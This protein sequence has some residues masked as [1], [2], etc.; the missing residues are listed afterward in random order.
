M[1][2][3]TVGVQ[4]VEIDGPSPEEAVEETTVRTQ[5]LRMHCPGQR[6]KVRER[7]VII[8]PAVG[9]LL[10]NGAEIEVY[11]KLVQGFYQ[12]ANGQVII[13]HYYNAKSFLKI[14]L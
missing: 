11:S 9:Q 8:E 12:L 4:W 13:Y 3:N 5:W 7:P 14:K 2:K 10:A 6:L 1:N